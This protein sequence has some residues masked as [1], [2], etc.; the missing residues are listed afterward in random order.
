[1]S[2]LNDKLF[3]LEYELLS[4]SEAEALRVRIQEEPELAEEYE[5][6][7]SATTLIAKAALN[8]PQKPI[9]YK[10][11][12]KTEEIEDEKTTVSPPPELPDDLG[13][14]FSTALGLV[15][16]TPLRL[17]PPSVLDKPSDF[18]SVHERPNKLVNPISGWFTRRYP[19]LNQRII[20][21][22]I[23]LM[24]FALSG[25]FVELRNRPNIAEDL[26]RMEVVGPN[27]FARNT[28]GTLSISVYDYAG[29]AK[30]A[31]VRLDLSDETGKQFY[32]YQ[33]KTDSKGQ[34]LVSLDN[35]QT[36]PQNV[37]V[38]ITAGNKPH[39]NSIRA[40]IPVV[41]QPSDPIA[42]LSQLDV[43]T[44]ANISGIK[45][46]S[47]AE[48]DSESLC[49]TFFSAPVAPNAPPAFPGSE[50]KG[51]LGIAIP[52]RSNTFVENKNGNY[53]GGTQITSPA[54]SIPEPS[55]QKPKSPLELS[56]QSGPSELQRRSVIAD[57]CDKSEQLAYEESGNKPED[58]GKEPYRVWEIGSS[59]SDSSQ[60]NDATGDAGMGGGRSGEIVARTGSLPP[61]K[62]NAEF[63]RRRGMGGMGGLTD[64]LPSVNA[65]SE[66]PSKDPSDEKLD[67]RVAEDRSLFVSLDNPE[68]E[69]GPTVGQPSKLQ[70]E[71]RNF[72]YGEPI[73][74][75]IDSMEQ[76]VPMVA[77]L[78]QSGV[79]IIEKQ[80][81]STGTQTAVSLEVPEQIP[82]G[83]LAVSAFDYRTNPPQKI[84]EQSVFYR[85]K[86][87]LKI[88]QTG[89]TSAFQITNEAGKPTEANIRVS[90]W[91]G[92]PI[93]GESVAAPIV[94]NNSEEIRTDYQRLS[95]NRKPLLSSFFGIVAT[96]G[97]VG[98][99]VILCCVVILFF[100]RM[101][102]G[103]GSLITPIASGILG[104][105]LTVSLWNSNTLPEYVEHDKYEVQAT[106]LSA[107]T[108][109]D[110]P[111][112]E[113]PESRLVDQW[114]KKT[115]SFGVCRFPDLSEYSKSPQ[116]TI[117]IEA[118]AP[119]RTGFLEL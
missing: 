51:T 4:E 24:V 89:D 49:E 90:I 75:Q 84:A 91:A 69:D 97:I 63:P 28:V 65:I 62:S 94:L 30:Q 34:L 20:I 55:V 12:A 22:S 98:G 92:A 38:E 95:A 68:M 61:A 37:L 70:L 52:E 27:V 107:P 102:S 83:M 57:A 31:P 23:V 26:L 7:K 100:R 66:E 33:E 56:S 50:S 88:E 13:T 64:G 117:R 72:A 87:H 41:D 113:T 59:S 109:D 79:P 15:P 25:Y 10:I 47:I 110:A 86:Q 16:K 71:K 46:L 9:K 11:P 76:G 21:S 80:I 106:T 18:E 48:N 78:S 36:L 54:S 44:Y 111:A 6:V 5:K 8:G 14:S 77:M 114:M 93:D 108:K 82:G 42:K 1:M 104:I 96:I 119:D 74:L 3:E 35:S 115:D 105:L 17:I 43:P 60:M 112:P 2:T 67:V 116:Y 29:N 81:Q 39:L 101:L 103:Y 99:I 32:T 58:R 19:R 118:A 73:Q 85:G 45:P 40:N 53:R